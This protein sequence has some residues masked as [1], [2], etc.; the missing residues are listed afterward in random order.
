MFFRTT[1][2]RSLAAIALLSV[3]LSGCASSSFNPASLNYTQP[4]PAKGV[5]IGTVFERAVFEPYG[6]TFV[7]TP[8]NPAMIATNRIGLSSKAM[9]GQTTLRNV[10][11]KLPKGEGTTFALQLAPGRYRVSFWGLDYGRRFKY[12]ESPLQQI[13]FDVEA[14]KV[15]YI[16]RLDANRF[17]EM[18]SIHDNYAEDIE[19]LK[20]NP[21]LSNATIENKALEVREWWLPDATGKELL[22]RQ[23][24]Q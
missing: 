1:A 2:I 24:A 21:L 22:K 13:E 17:M 10:P 5:V 4:D 16:G 20:K 18:A 15:I 8:N 23:N 14:G 3:I 11:P 19:Y 6:A 7:I 12:S 9:A